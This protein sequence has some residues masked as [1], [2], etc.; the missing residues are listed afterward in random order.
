MMGAMRML[1]V[2]MMPSLLR[3]AGG[4][5]G[6]DVEVGARAELC[7]E[8]VM[9]SLVALVEERTM[10]LAGTVK[11]RGLVE[12]VASLRDLTHLSVVST[13]AVPSYSCS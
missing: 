2:V 3:L 11:L 9:M 6:P 1:G 5:D 8:N 13:C 12:A 4:R 7:T 10:Y